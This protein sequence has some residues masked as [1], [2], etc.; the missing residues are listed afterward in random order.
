MYRIGY[1]TVKVHTRAHVR[2]P[3]HSTAHGT[4]GSGPGRCLK[5]ARRASQ[6]DR[7]TTIHTCWHA[8]SRIPGTPMGAYL[9]K[10]GGLMTAYV[11]Q[12][13]PSGPLLALPGPSAYVVQPRASPSLPPIDLAS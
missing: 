1:V 13:V 10:P 7:N 2:A 5:L 11:A 9:R 8:Y 12:F 3:G 4:E 6:P